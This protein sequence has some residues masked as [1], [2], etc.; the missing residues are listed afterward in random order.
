MRSVKG[1]DSSPCKDLDDSELKNSAFAKT[2]KAL[3]EIGFRPE[4]SACEIFPYRNSPRT[5]EGIKFGFALL[6]QGKHPVSRFWRF[7]FKISY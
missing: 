6:G 7:I 1:N 3:G 4:F 5:M 2:I